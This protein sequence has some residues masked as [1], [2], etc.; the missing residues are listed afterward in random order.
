MAICL[1]CLLVLQ[2][3]EMQKKDGC[4]TFP[5]N[6]LHFIHGSKSHIT[7]LCSIIFSEVDRCHLSSVYTVH[8][9]KFHPFFSPRVSNEEWIYNPSDS[10]RQASLDPFLSDL[11]SHFSLSV[12]RTHSER[13]LD[14]AC[15]LDSF[16]LHRYVAG[17][18]LKVVMN[19]QSVPCVK[20]TPTFYLL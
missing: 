7:L 3:G 19:K 2:E 4:V 5:V 6:F 16:I 8:T 11:L 1:M 12:T 13:I 9:Y 15:V 10:F 18:Q 20:A 17:V 14:N